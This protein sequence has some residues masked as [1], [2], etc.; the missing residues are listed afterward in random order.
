MELDYPKG[1]PRNPLTDEEIEEKFDALAA[2]VL[3]REKAGRLKEA[4][5]RLEEVN[6]V[7]EL[8]ELCRSDL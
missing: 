2:G 3:S 7:T 6:S 4:V 1:D 8:M 5:W